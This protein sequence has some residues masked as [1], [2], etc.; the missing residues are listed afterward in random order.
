MPPSP[1]EVKDFSA[2]RLASRR[3]GRDRP[4]PA[5]PRNVA[6]AA[7]AVKIAAPALG[8]AASVATAQP[9]SHVAV[10]AAASPATASSATPAS[11]A[12]PVGTQESATRPAASARN[13]QSER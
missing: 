7:P 8:L 6:G 9:V 3:G 11:A 12:S 2:E 13:S 1:F 4:H 10:A 5:P